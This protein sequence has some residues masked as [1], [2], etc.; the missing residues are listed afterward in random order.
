[1]KII[2]RILRDDAYDIMY[3]MTCF[4]LFT[5]LFWGISKAIIKLACCGD[6]NIKY[7]NNIINKDIVSCNYI[8]RN[9]AKEINKY[10]AENEE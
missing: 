10:F 8:S 7:S 3:R 1:M 2:Q 4:G 6:D 9:I 5:G